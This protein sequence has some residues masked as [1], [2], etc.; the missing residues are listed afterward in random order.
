MSSLRSEN[1]RKMERDEDV[2]SGS[3]TGGSHALYCF[4]R[5]PESGYMLQCELC[6]EWFH[7]TCLHI[8]KG[9]RVPGKDTGKDARFLCPSCQR[10]RRPRLDPIVALLI[11][12]QKIPVRISEGTA[13]QCL[14]ERSI[15]WQK[16]ARHGIQGSVSTLEAA[17]QQK[18]RIEEIKN[19]ITRWRQEASAILNSST[20]S[21]QAQ[22]ANSAGLCAY[23]IH[24]NSN[25]QVN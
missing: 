23:V 1:I 13:L 20:T 14:A 11:S 17:K 16:K 18:R 22:L 21:M 3:L 4:C 19:H 15:T 6:H 9:K 12:L 10:T 25:Q 24:C 2:K 7:A 8:P 5:K